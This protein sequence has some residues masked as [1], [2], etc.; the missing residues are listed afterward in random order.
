MVYSDYKISDYHDGD[1]KFYLYL[2]S[3]SYIVSLEYDSDGKVLVYGKDGD[4]IS[5]ENTPATGDYYRVE[6]YLDNLTFDIDEDELVHYRAPWSIGNREIIANTVGEI[7][8][9]MVFFDEYTTSGQ[10]LHKLKDGV[11]ENGEVSYERIE[12]DK[13]DGAVT[14]EAA[15]GKHVFVGNSITGYNVTYCA[16]LEYGAVFDAGNPS[17]LPDGE[18]LEF[19]VLPNAGYV[20]TE[21]SWSTDLDDT[22]QPLAVRADGEYAIPVQKG[23]VFVTVTAVPEYEIVLIADE[24]SSGTFEYSLNGGVAI[25]YTDAPIKVISTDTL[26]VTATTVEHFRF[27]EWDRNKNRNARYSDTSPILT[28]R[29]AGIRGV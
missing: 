17:K 4:L 11:L 13:W 26:S 19:K 23:H 7:L 18:G 1:D 9:Q 5:G 22:D 2:P 10:I 21:I 20:I 25:E 24:A 29:F 3:D 8:P 15:G 12:P 16:D 27:I 28:Q 6:Y 14:F